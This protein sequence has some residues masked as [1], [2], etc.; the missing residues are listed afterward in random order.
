M[1]LRVLRWLAGGAVCAALVLPAAAGDDLQFR[2]GLGVVGASEFGF[3]NDPPPYGAFLEVD[4]MPADWVRVLGKSR[5]LWLEKNSGGAGSQYDVG[6]GVEFLMYDS[7]VAGGCRWDTAYLEVAEFDKTRNRQSCHFAYQSPRVRF[8]VGLRLK[9][10]TAEQSHGPYVAYRWCW[11]T[12]S[13]KTLVPDCYQYDLHRADF[14]VRPGGERDA[15]W[16]ERTGTAAAFQIVW[17][18]DD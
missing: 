6:V 1:R 7:G 12:K 13:G 3:T 15:D 2:L 10:D 14:R 8:E 5:Y 17:R 11:N 16:E 9:T 4:W 18:L